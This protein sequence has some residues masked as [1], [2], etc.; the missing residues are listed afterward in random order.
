MEVRLGRDVDF[1]QDV[2]LVTPPAL[3]DENID[4]NGP[5]VNGVNGDEVDESDDDDDILISGRLKEKKGKDGA[6]GKAIALGQISHKLLT[7]PNW[8][9]LYD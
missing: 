7:I 8:T 3:Q 5:H 9:A 6:K 4:S 2:V 1:L